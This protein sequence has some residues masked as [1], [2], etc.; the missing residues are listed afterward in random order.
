M[1][2]VQYKN[3]NYNVYID[4]DNGTKIRKN[5]EDCFIPNTVESM[6]IK[7]TNKCTLGSNCAYC[8]E[9]SGPSG[10]HGDI[11]SPSFLDKLHPYTELALGGGNILEHPDID[12]FLKRCKER[13]HI[14]NITVNQK[15]FI[16]NFS[17]IKNWVDDKLVYGVGISFTEPSYDLIER[18]KKIPNSVIHV[19]AGIVEM[20]E[21][22][23]LAR[24][25]LKILILGYKQVRR[26]EQ[27]YNSLHATIDRR[28]SNLAYYL[29]N[30]IDEKW[31]SV[32]SFDNLAI[33]QLNVRKLF[34]DEKWNEFYMGDDGQDGQQTSASMF[35]DM[36]ERKFAKNSCAPENERYDLLDTAEEMYTYLVNNKE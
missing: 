5:D 26:G 16:E 11:L 20:S 3:G 9:G 21:L 28:I 27:L 10:R 35:V 14:C 30:M 29:K 36:V 13:N 17:R 15:H 24:N 12:E 32:I 1:N 23:F 7:I 4:L 6:D 19:I 8:H 2:W 34:T 33:K 18:A 25:D 31:F 22:N